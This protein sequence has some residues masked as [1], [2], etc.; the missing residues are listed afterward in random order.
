M[1]SQFP[2]QDVAAEESLAAIQ[3]NTTGLIGA[4]DSIAT[5]VATAANQVEG[6]NTLSSIEAS[7]A[8]AANQTTANTSLASL[9]TGQGTDGTGITPPAGGTGI[10]GWLSGIYNAIIGTLSVTQSIGGN[11]ISPTNPLPIYDGY[12]APVS[13]TWTTATTANTAETVSTAGMDTVIVTLV[14]NSSITGGTVIFEVYDGA[15]W[16][17]VKAPTVIDYTTVGSI[18]LTASY[19]KGFQVPVAGFPQF[20]V[21][22]SSVLVANNVDCII[23]TGCIIGYCRS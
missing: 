9:V 18:N 8:T 3:T 2:V 17:P 14:G 19:T 22:L 6:N 13:T 23:S 16:L 20:R 5:S 4:I 1:S 11:T 15:T 21:R 10:R 12:T 7:V